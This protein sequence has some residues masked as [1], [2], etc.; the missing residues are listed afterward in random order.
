MRSSAFDCNDQDDHVWPKAN[1]SQD[2]RASRPTARPR[3]STATA[4]A[5]DVEVVGEGPFGAEHCGSCFDACGGETSNGEFKCLRAGE[6]ERQRLHPGV[7]RAARGLRWQDRERLRDC[8]HRPQPSLLSRCRRRWAWRPEHAALR[9]RRQRRARG[10][11]GG[12]LGLRRPRQQRVRRG[13]CRRGGRRAA[14]TGCDNDCAGAVDD[15]P[16]LGTACSVP[17]KLGVCASG[18]YSCQGASGA[19]LCLRTN[20]ASAELCDGLDNDCDGTLDNPPGHLHDAKYDLARRVPRQA[21]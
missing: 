13:P 21:I 4:Q 5:D 15:V 16:A 11:R 19:P 8:R 10:L 3:T 9:L 18:A 6:G 20:V 1:L 2:T 12:R 7:R 17:G 14:A